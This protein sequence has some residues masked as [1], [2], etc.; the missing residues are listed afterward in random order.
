MLCAA[1][2]HMTDIGRGRRCSAI[3]SNPDVLALKSTRD[4][5]AKRQRLESLQFLLVYLSF[6]CLLP[7]QCLCESAIGYTDL[8]ICRAL[9][10]AFFVRSLFYFFF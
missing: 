9:A 4:V 2:A 8:L 1:K 6:V 7:S 10:C 3:D 5:L